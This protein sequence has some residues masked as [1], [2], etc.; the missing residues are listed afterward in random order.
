M[1]FDV[2]AFE[3]KLKELN[4]PKTVT[5]SPAVFWEVK[6]ATEAPLQVIE[7]GKGKSELSFKYEVTTVLL[8]EPVMRPD[9][10][11][12]TEFGVAPPVVEGKPTPRPGDPGGPAPFIPP[13]TPPAVH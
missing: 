7:V 8:A 12:L 13:F 9:K 3:E 1:A 4:W 11:D 10:S 6:K 5:L 2:T